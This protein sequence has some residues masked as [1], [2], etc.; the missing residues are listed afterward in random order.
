MSTLAL[1]TGMIVVSVAPPV[2]SAQEVIEAPGVETPILGPPNLL[3]SFHDSLRRT[4][5]GKG[6]TR[7]LVFG[8]S[9]TAADLLTGK[10]RKL[11][12][13]RFGDGGHGFLMPAR[14]WRSYRRE[15]IVWEGPK[16]RWAR[17]HWDYARLK[18]RCHDD[19]LYGLAGMSVMASNKRR[20]DRFRTR[21]R[22]SKASYFELIYAKQQKGGDLY[23]RIDGGI[24][25]RIKTRGNGGF[26]VWKSQLKLGSHSFEIRPKGN[27]NV[28]LYGA[29][30]ERRKSG[31]VVDTLGINGARAM[32]MLRWN[33]TLWSKLV[34]HRDP[35]LIILAYGT[36]EAGDTSEDISIYQS[37]LKKVLAR[38]RKAAPNASCVLVGPSDRPLVNKDTGD[39]SLISFSKRPRTALII[40]TQK[41]L[42]AEAGCGFWDMVTATGGPFSIVSWADH[43]PRYAWTDYV[44]LTSRGYRRLAGIFTTALL[45]GYTS[46]EE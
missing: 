34:A 25:R 46:T 21:E 9:H 29:V 18:P 27:G 40:E 2:G 7:I 15:G 8:A 3:S 31:V 14:P 6:K 41:R 13:T 43:E 11:L 28:R 37:Q 22:G 1:I 16:T 5:K 33:E 4:E 42:S 17:W 36:N 24:R 35:A 10:M 26:G 23:L 20:W 45:Q 30:V 44:H 38:V 39:R 32:Q 19:G 12:Q